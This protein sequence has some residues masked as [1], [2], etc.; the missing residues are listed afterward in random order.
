VVITGGGY[1][2]AAATL[3]AGA[4]SVN[5]PAGALNSGTDALTATYGGD[6][7]YDTFAG[8]T[9][10]TV[11][12]VAITLGNLTPVPPGTSIT[13]TA[14]LLAGS[15]YSGTMNLSCTLTT[16]PSGAENLPTCGFSPASITVT[17]GK[18]N[19]TTMTVRTTTAIITVAQSDTPGLKAFGGGGAALAA[20]LMFGIASR[21]RRWMSM[22]ILIFVIAVGGA[23]GCGG[24]GGASL[25]PV[26]GTNATTKGSYTFTVTSS[27]STN[28]AIT[29]STNFTITVQ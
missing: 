17:S 23:I 18:S 19:P 6:T 7:T 12:Q 10:V 8:N 4:A 27:D 21:R 11:S 13:G 26:D 29:A 2:S 15:T 24:A 20:M 5:I 14:T 22:L 25:Q 9:S 16:S 3:S 1:T 28:P